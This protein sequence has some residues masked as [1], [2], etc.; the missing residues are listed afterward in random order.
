MKEKIRMVS[1]NVV[2]VMFLIFYYTL[3]WVVSGFGILII[4]VT[5]ISRYREIL[6]QLKENE[7][8]DEIKNK[9]DEFD[10]LDGQELC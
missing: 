1:V 7:E 9:F 10:E 3:L 8:L 5:V 4:P 6:K 2:M